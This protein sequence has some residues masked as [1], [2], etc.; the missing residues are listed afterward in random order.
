MN[1]LLYTPDNQVTRNYMPHLWM[2]VLQSLTPPEHEVFLIDGNA[3]P[4]T[5]AEVAQFVRDNDIKLAGIGAMTRVAARAYRMADAIRAAGAQ[6]IMG[7]PHVT[8]VPGEAIGRDDE[9]RH[10]DAVAL[11]EVDDLWPQ[12]LRDAEAGELKETYRALDD[13]G[14]EIKPSLENYARIPWET[15]DLEQ[16]NLIEKI[17]AW[18]RFLMK[19]AGVKNWNSLYVLPVESG[20]GC[21]YGCD[22]CT[23]TGFFGKSIRFRSDQC[24]VDELLR[25]KARAAREGGKVGVFFIDDNFAINK[26]RTK[27][28]LREMIAR[29]AQ[30]PW[31]AQ[32]SMNLL[33]DEELVD[34]IAESGGIWIF[35]GLESIDPGNL[36]EVN[37]GFNKPAEYKAVLDRLAE[38]G[39]YAITSFIFGMDGDRKGVARN[40]LDAI[41]SWP[42]GLPVFG[43]LTPYPAT[44]LYDRLL[45]QGRLT[46]P[47][48]WLDFRPFQMAFTPQNVSI[49]EAE[50]EVHEAWSRCYDPPAI[51]AA[52]RKIEGRPFKERAVMFFTRLAFR[53]I[54][55]PQMSA[56]HWIKL[57]F[58]NRRSLFKLVGEAITARRRRRAAKAP[59]DPS[60]D[61]TEPRG[62]AA[63]KVELPRSKSA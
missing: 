20:R 34:L 24:V 22:F 32:I 50:A 21:P 3:Q 46:R 13:D 31:V 56:R 12:I 40:T 26:K 47:K 49:E 19:R 58:Q 9:P 55:F 39:I 7:G 8:E 38:R 25:L 27:S 54:Y 60:S 59:S 42:P 14:R 45:D 62:L 48:H 52:L 6:V 30:V 33:K 36:K 53:G 1:I 16:F 29:D 41:D 10:A 4:L 43:L 5:E 23:V 37:K 35:M 61:L 63:A 17:P 15:M 51:A 44:P 28:L 11:G 2:F 18:G 57:L